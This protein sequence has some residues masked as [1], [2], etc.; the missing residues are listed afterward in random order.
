MVLY[1]SETLHRNVS[2]KPIRRFA[3]PTLL[4]PLGDEKG[5][6]CV[7]KIFLNFPLVDHIQKFGKPAHLPYRHNMNAVGDAPQLVYEFGRDL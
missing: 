6:I 1:K 3:P 2:T 4:S 5:R 7:C